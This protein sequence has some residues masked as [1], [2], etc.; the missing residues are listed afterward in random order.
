MRVQ[1]SPMVSPV[2]GCYEKKDRTARVVIS[3]RQAQGS[4]IWDALRVIS[5]WILEISMEVLTMS[6]V[7]ELR[8]SL[9]KRLP[10]HRLH[11]SQVLQPL[12]RG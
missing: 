2:Y 9:P 3:G 6:P 1:K 5:A 10:T 8:S 7:V 4:D 12:K 11:S